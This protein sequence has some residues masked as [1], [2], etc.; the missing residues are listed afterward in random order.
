MAGCN[1]PQAG[2]ALLSGIPNPSTTCLELDSRKREF[3]YGAELF[4]SIR[5]IVATANFWETKD[6]QIF[7]HMDAGKEPGVTEDEIPNWLV[8]EGES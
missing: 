5:Y 8:S 6:K 4:S 3:G 7:T 2:P 1:F